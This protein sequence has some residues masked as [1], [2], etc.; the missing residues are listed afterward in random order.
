MKRDIKKNFWF[1]KKEDEMLKRKAAMCNVSEANLVR[2]LVTDFA[3]RE[4]PPWRFY[5]EL[6]E[7]NMVCV[8]LRQ[9]VATANR[10]GY[11]NTDEIEKVIGQISF[12]ILNIKRHYTLPEYKRKLSNLYEEEAYEQ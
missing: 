9:L 12:F 2:M 10:E 5:R 1:S 7:L 8:H 11:K 4:A 3:P 6:K